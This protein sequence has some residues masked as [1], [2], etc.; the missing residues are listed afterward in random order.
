MQK[1]EKEPKETTTK[2]E[3]VPAKEE[4]PAQEE[5]PFSP[6]DEN[7]IPEPDTTLFVKNLNFST[8]EPSMK[9]VQSRPCNVVLG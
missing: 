2:I 8:T 6:V 4:T 9:K 3:N 5:K 7:W 1:E